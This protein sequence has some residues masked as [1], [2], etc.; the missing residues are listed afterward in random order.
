MSKQKVLG[1]PLERFTRMMFSR[2]IAG[3]ARE[4]HEEDFSVAQVAALHLVDHGG[5]MRVTVLAT[6]LGLSASAG[7]RLAEGLVQRGLLARQEDPED[8]R[9][10]TLA[11]TPLG[12]RFVDRASVERVRVIMETAESLPREI[13]AAM[14]AAI[15]AYQRG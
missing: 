2:I 7:S 10:K 13:S 12:R 11:L 3:L 8:R 6:S 14:L 15:D 9:A 5:P 4:L 1:S